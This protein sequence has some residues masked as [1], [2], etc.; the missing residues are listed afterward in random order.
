MGLFESPETWLVS[1]SI[2]PSDCTKVLKNNF[3]G[4]NSFISF[5]PS[6]IA[7]NCISVKESRFFESLA[8]KIAKV[9]I[10]AVKI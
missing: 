2:I 10:V 9:L 1:A 6:S 7:V 5:I 3:V 8:I 4:F